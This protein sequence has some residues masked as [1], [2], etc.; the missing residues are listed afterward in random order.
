[1]SL[2][3]AGI[4]KQCPGIY[5]VLFNF[6]ILGQEM[7][8]VSNARTGDK[9]PPLVF[10]ICIYVGP[11][12]P[13]PY[14]FDLF[15]CFKDPDLARQVL[16]KP[17]S[18]L[19]LTTIPEN[20]LAVYKD[21]DVY[22]HLLKQAVHKKFLNWVENH[23]EEITKLYDSKYA[24]EGVFYMLKAEEEVDPEVLIEKLRS[25]VNDKNNI[26][27]SAAQKLID[28]GVQKGMQLGEEKGTFIKAIEIARSMLQDKE[29]IER[30]IK[31]TGLGKAELEKILQG[32]R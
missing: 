4:V 21:L 6:G 20:D 5:N 30:I 13:Y 26:T 7:R 2:K 18:A 23:I 28:R 9:Y 14:S 22:L 16:F 27:M 17:A 3:P 8:N 29:P 15:N 32:S 1:M 10:N 25:I 11:K 24:E 12:S 31:W 19:D